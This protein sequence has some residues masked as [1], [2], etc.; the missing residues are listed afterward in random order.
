ML[1]E[2]SD[3][4]RC[5]LAT[6]LE[7]HWALG[8]IE[9]EYLPVG[10]GA[11]HWLAAD[12]R[13]ARWFVTADDLD[14][15]F[16]HGPDADS[17]LAAL[18]R[19][20]RTAAALRDGA[21][22]EFVVAPSPDAD[23]A[24]TRRLSDRYAV[25]VSPYLEGES[26]SYGA[27]ESAEERRAMGRVLGRLHAATGRIP[28]DLPRT[29]DFAVP[30]RD[31]LMEALRD[32]DRPWVSGPFGEPARLLLRRNARDVER[33]LEQYDELA[34]AV[35]ERSQPWV[36]THGEP[37]RANVVRGARGAVFL[38]DW[39]TTLLAPRERDLRMVLDED[40]TGWDEYV[41]GAGPVELDERAMLLYRTWWDLADTALFVD[42]F[43]R[44]HGRTEDDQ[45]SWRALTSYLPDR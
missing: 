10:F 23:G 42:R 33:R 19:A 22:L 34:E 12:A 11:H 15:G 36:I 9:L 3:L 43:R 28:P 32:L 20:Y 37:H 14:A 26:T 35:G 25:T 6:L 7:R 38:V 31:A 1:T 24:L 30:A 41:A 27:Y 45:A 17:A 39:D 29:D 21:Q 4:D 8:E 16:Q 2:P 5:A 18:E 13:G 40:M 44:P